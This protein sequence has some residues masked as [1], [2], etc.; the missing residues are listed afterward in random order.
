MWF[1]QLTGIRPLK[2][3]ERIEQ[4]KCRRQ[5]YMLDVL[6]NGGVNEDEREP[7]DFL[8]EDWIPPYLRRQAE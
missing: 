8:Q 5:L 2:D 3:F 6:A 1:S 4:W 7:L